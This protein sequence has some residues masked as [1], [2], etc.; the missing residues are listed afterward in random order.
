MAR[1][2]GANSWWLRAITLASSGALASTVAVGC[3]SSSGP[4]PTAYVVAYVNTGAGVTCNYNV[5]TTVFTEG[6]GPETNPTGVGNGTN[7]NG[8]AVTVGC[9]VTGSGSFAVSADVT[10]VAAGSFSL[11]GTMTG[12]GVQKGISAS[13]GNGTS[14]YSSA[15]CTFTFTSATSPPIK[16]GAVWGQLDCPDMVTGMPGVACVGSA[17]VQLTNCTQ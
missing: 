13:F 2:A 15:D 14:S 17:Q 1:R 4:P 12:S 16:A 3:G 6:S 7:V 9:A 8:S 5:M 10:T 11:H